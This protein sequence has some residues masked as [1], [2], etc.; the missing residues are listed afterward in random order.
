MNKPLLVSII[1]VLIVFFA[2]IVYFWCL[3]IETYYEGKSEI[4]PDTLD[5]LEHG[6]IVGEWNRMIIYPDTTNDLQLGITM[7]MWGKIK[8]YADTII[9]MNP[10]TVIIW[11]VE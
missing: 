4:Q 7:R 11:D 5:F 6:S 3:G 10:E 9:V 8:V 1:L 2:A